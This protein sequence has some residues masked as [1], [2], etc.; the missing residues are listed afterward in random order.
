MRKHI[1]W[2]PTINN[3]KYPDGRRITSKPEFPFFPRPDDINDHITALESYVR[4]LRI[5]TRTV[6]EEGFKRRERL[7]ADNNDE[8][9]GDDIAEITQALREIKENMKPLFE[10]SLDQTLTNMKESAAN[11]EQFR[12]GD[13]LL[14]KTIDDANVNL[15]NAMQKIQFYIYGSKIRYRKGTKYM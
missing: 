8:M 13:A 6:C 2:V 3:T 15:N 14:R 10:E 9:H 11:S 7:I 4:F 1:E 5:L 12:E